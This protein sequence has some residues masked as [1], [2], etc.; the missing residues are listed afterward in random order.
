MRIK[1]LSTLFLAAL[2]VLA[3]AAGCSNTQ[4]D[5]ALSTDIKAK[6]FS[7][8][9]VKAANVDVA[10]KDGEVTISGEVPDDGARYKAYKIASDAPG[11]KHVVDKMTVQAAQATP[12]PEP[13]QA[14]PL[15]ARKPV[16]KAEKHY[17][18]SN[19]QS[20]M[21]QP[22]PPSAPPPSAASAPPAQP[23]VAAPPPPPPP[24][25]P[26]RVEIPAGTSVRVQMIDGVDSSVNHAGEIFQASLA[27]PIV[28]DDQIVVPAGTDMYVKLT[29]AKSAGHMTGQ[30]TLALEL[31]RMEFQ[32]KSYALASN[33]Y[34]Q[35]GSS[36]GKRTAETVG[37]GAVLGTLLGAVIGG[38]KGAAIGAATGAGAGGVAQGVTKGQQVQIKPETKLDF[39][40]EQ[41]VEVSYFPDKNRT[42]RP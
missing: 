17:V 7:D 22:D 31:V 36:R 16:R 3:L 6:M 14:R 23:A 25:Q 8:S 30:S 12:A 20:P 29:N 38:G 2:S 1:S 24:P 37:G 18:K 33:D 27:S 34:Q 28:V 40:L 39:S 5:Q 21:S 13:A 15:P 19:V 4:R 26:K 10:V 41:P 35:T 11:V 32:G 9:Q 42:Q